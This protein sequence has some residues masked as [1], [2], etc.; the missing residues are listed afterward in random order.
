VGAR[1]DVFQI[2][3][4]AGGAT[5]A[6]AVPI[7]MQLFAKAYPAEPFTVPPDFDRLKARFKRWELMSQL[8]FFPFAAVFTYLIWLLFRG[9]ATLR[10]SLLPSAEFALVVQEFVWLLPSMFLSIFV[11]GIALEIV[12]YLIFGSDDY[13]VLIKFVNNKHRMNGQIVMRILF[14]VTVII[15]TAFIVIGLNLYMLIDQNGLVISR[16]F[17]LEPTR[18]LYEDITNITQT[19]GYFAPNGNFIQNRAF[20]ISLS[21]GSSLSSLNEISI[22]ALPEVLDRNQKLGLLE[23]LSQRSGKPIENVAPFRK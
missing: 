20:E 2:G 16:L 13:N 4:I 17:S 11:T 22:L 3:A 19:D 12:T 7:V 6:I 14:P 10:T 9:L 21:D 15:C 8:A 5:A 18:Y 1:V 23:I